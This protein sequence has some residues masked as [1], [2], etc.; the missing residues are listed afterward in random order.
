MTRNV[1]DYALV[2]GNPARIQ[3]WMCHCG[4]RLRLEEDGGIETAV[5]KACGA[6]YSKTGEIVKKKNNPSCEYT[7]LMRTDKIRWLLAA[8]VL[9]VLL[10]ISIFFIGRT[11]ILPDLFDSNGIGSFGSDSREYM[12]EVKY[13]VEILRN[14]GAADWLQQLPQ[15]WHNKIVSL[16]FAIL[17]PLFGFTI[18]S[19][20]LFNLVCY[21]TIL[22]LIFTLGSEIFNQKVGI[23]AAIVVGLWPSFLLHTTQLLKDPLF[24]AGLL[25]LLL[26]FTRCFNGYQRPVGALVHT[27]IGIIIVK[28]LQLIRLSWW[29][30]IV[31][32]AALG[33]LGILLQI[34]VRRP[35][36]WYLVGLALVLIA[37]LAIQYHPFTSHLSRSPLSD[38]S[39]VLH[40][41]R[42]V[43]PAKL[44][45]L[46]L[47]E[48]DTV[49][50][51]IS[52]YRR[53]FSTVYSATA[54]NIDP[55]YRIN[56]IQDVVRYLP[57]AITIGFFSPFPNMWLAEGGK[58]GLSARAL[59]GV[60]TIVVYVIEIMAAVGIW[61]SRRQ[62]SVWYLFSV[63]SIGVVTLALVVPNVGTLYRWRYPFWMILVLLGV[64]GF[65]QVVWL[66]LRKVLPSYS[67]SAGEM[68]TRQ[69]NCIW[70]VSSGLGDL[71]PKGM[72][73]ESRSNGCK[74]CL[75]RLISSRRARWPE[76]RPWRA[77]LWRACLRQGRLRMPKAVGGSSAYGVRP[78]GATVALSKCDCPGIRVHKG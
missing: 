33:V 36:L 70:I 44:W 29:P 57:R 32:I 11:Q 24:I 14:E 46:L 1:P 12:G 72:L 63:A 21:L 76:A 71:S 41:H 54:S 22:F 43:D 47:I 4:I 2:Y 17:A 18:L 73:R 64:S 26:I 65:Q 27:G 66:H 69:G 8:A 67:K 51:R 3:G 5:C 42:D 10:T 37:A 58:L 53:A 45:D 62:L 19:A 13:L 6:K 16:S 77:R 60:E 40:D 34:L 68:H 50:M 31:A 75:R 23:V 38:D 61:H 74:T 15:Q 20:E 49:A 52:N 7:P 48:A 9:H 25:G 55:Q 35:K 56:T 59:S 30:L 78:Y 39:I 28:M